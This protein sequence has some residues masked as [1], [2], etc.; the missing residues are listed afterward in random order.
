MDE[1]DKVAF[2]FNKLINETDKRECIELFAG[3]LE[4][5]IENEKESKD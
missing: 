1:F 4:Q 2:L 3:Y 5:M